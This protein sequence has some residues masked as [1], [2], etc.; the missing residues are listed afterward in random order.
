MLWNVNDVI[1]YRLAARDGSIGSVS[2]L[3][4]DDHTSQ[5]RYLVV[6]TGE[7]LPGRKVLLV[8]GV[9]GGADPAERA[10]PVELSRQQVKDSPDLSTDQPVS[11]QE[12]LRLHSHYAWEPYWA[13]PPAAMVPPY[14][15]AA[16]YAHGTMPA[17]GRRGVTEPAAERAAAARGDPHLRSASEVI[18]YY[19]EASDGDI[20]H[21]EDL[22][23]E[24]A[25]WTIRY[26]VIDTR[27]WLP[28]RKVIISPQ[29]LRWVDWGS[30]KIGVD[31]PRERIENSPEYDPH[32]A[33]E[34][35]HEEALH[36]HY[37]RP[38]Y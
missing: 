10:F 32:A 21:V 29:W 12:E 35:R 4:F 36:R 19:V 16:G 14:W 37:E 9:L 5:V 26:I 18:G 24:D 7:W 2:D 1:G 20:G 38:M 3:L 28:G 27:N 17:S 31:L 22:L 11:R 30:Q 8:P 33:L 25:T 23:V 6:D 15:S 13:A 34:R